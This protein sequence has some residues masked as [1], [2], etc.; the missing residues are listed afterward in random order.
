MPPKSWTHS[1]TCAPLALPLCSAACRSYADEL[2]L[3]VLILN[4]V[5]DSMNVP[6]PHDGGGRENRHTRDRRLAAGLR[7][8]SLGREVSPALGLGECLK[9]W[10]RPVRMCGGGVGGGVL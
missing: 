9:C 3:A 6:S 4:Q 10:S 7:L 5:S 2:N 8:T 1:V